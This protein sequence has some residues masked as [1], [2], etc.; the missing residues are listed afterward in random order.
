MLCSAWVVELDILDIVPP[1]W[2][3]DERCAFA[4]KRFGQASMGLVLGW[5]LRVLLALIL[6]HIEK[7]KVDGWSYV[8]HLGRGA[9]VLLLENCAFGSEGGLHA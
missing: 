9:F 6:H 2:R 7:D 3:V 1:F 8:E 5:R 4:K